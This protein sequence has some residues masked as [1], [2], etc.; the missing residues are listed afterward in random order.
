MIRNMFARAAQATARWSGS[1]AATAAAIGAILLWAVVGPYFHYSDTWQLIVNTGT[2]V[3]TFLM[4]FLIQNSQNRDTGAIQMK[5][6]ELIRVTEAARN[7]LVQLEELPEEEVEEIKESFA[8]VAE[9]GGT[10]QVELEEAR[11]S[12]QEAEREIDEAQDRLDQVERKRSE[13][14]G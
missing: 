7:K 9:Q 8:R 6:D 1:P 4:V 13:K 10:G 11:A 14:A 5:L 3:A 12:L 2:S